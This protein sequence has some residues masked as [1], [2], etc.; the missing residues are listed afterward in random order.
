MASVLIRNIGQL[1]SGDLADPLIQANSLYIDDGK[2][3]EIDTSRTDAD[4]V[5]DAMGM[6]V[7]PGL[8]D[9]HSHPTHGDYHT[10]LNAQNWIRSYLHGSG[11]TTMVSAGEQHI[12]GIPYEEPQEPQALKWEAMFS[13][14]AWE[15]VRPAGVKVRAGTMLVVPGLVEQDF[16]DLAAAGCTNIKFIFYPFHRDWEEGKRYIQWARERG[17]VSKFHTGGVSRTGVSQPAYAKEVV[18][19]KPDVAGHITGGPISM[20]TDDLEAI[21]ADSEVYLEI[22]AQANYR[23]QYEFLEL[24]E[25]HNAWHR[26]I[27]GTDTPTGAGF[28]PR[29]ILRTLLF[30][31]GVGGFPPEKTLAL[32]SGNVAKAHRLAE[33]TIA[34]GKPADL[35]IMGSVRGGVSPATDALESIRQGDL[36]GITVV[37]IDGKVV[38]RDRAEQTPPPEILARFEKG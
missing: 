12:P 15:R 38:I 14:R 36:P 7:T 35:V 25:K 5:I 34:V 18:G 21:I 32:A 22:V 6:T 9:S 28:M 27:V 3:A 29:G 26:V 11:V 20:G 30:V 17:M 31:A 1:V 8:M 24:V 4:T 19:L 37:L 23:R 13:R 33:G 16:D 10:L 2:F